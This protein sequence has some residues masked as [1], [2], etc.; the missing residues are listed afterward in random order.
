VSRHAKSAHR[1]IVELVRML[2]HVFTNSAHRLNDNPFRL[3]GSWFPVYGVRVFARNSAGNRWI[4]AWTSN[5]LRRKLEYRSEVDRLIRW[6]SEFG[7]N[8]DFRLM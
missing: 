1:S 4:V 6:W 7:G 8:L 2:V 3:P 5:G